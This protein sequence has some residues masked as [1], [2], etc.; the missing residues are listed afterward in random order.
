M[1]FETY[2]FSP[3]ALLAAMEHRSSYFCCR[4]RLLTYTHVARSLIQ[5]TFGMF[6]PFLADVDCEPMYRSSPLYWDV[7]FCKFFLIL[8]TSSAHI[9][10]SEGRCNRRRFRYVLFTHCQLGNR[11]LEQKRSNPAHRTPIVTFVVLLPLQK[12]I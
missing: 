3:P 6:D 4:I 2:I 5:G 12:R 11:L 1:S 10:K 7:C 9:W 8:P